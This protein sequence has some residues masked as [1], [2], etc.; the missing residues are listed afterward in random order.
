MTSGFGVG[1]R[2]AVVCRSCHAVPLVI[3]S[4]S[5]NSVH[6]GG[7]VVAFPRPKVL[8]DVSI[9]PASW[10]PRRPG[11]MRQTHGTV[12][13]PR[14]ARPAGPTRC[15]RPPAGPCA[16]PPRRSRTRP[17]RHLSVIRPRRPPPAAWPVRPGRSRDPEPPPP[18]RP[19]APPARP[20]RKPG[21]GPAHQR[22]MGSPGRPA[23]RPSTGPADRRPAGSFVPRRTGSKPPSSDRG[24]RMTGDRF[25]RAEHLPEESFGG[26]LR[27]FGRCPAGSPGS[28]L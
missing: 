20:R 2:R 24:E 9:G 23:R 6:D 14:P 1:G 28:R 7:R 22:R 12:T 15:A 5:G 27:S 19:R 25:R 17:P 18:G 16:L 8:L 21:S 3:R 26:L 13:P 11:P 10:R 4:G